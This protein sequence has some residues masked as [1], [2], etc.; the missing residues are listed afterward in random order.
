MK[1]SK[2]ESVCVAPDPAAL[3]PGCTMRVLM[4]LYAAGHTVP[5][6]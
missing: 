1:G 6:L 2:Q 4:G 5:E 3:S